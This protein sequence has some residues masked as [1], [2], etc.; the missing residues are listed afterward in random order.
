MRL[1]KK[2]LPEQRHLWRETS[3]LADL[4][5][6][7]NQW[8]DALK[9]ERVGSYYDIK[10]CSGHGQGGHFHV[11]PMSDEQKLCN[12]ATVKESDDQEQ[13]CLQGDREPANA[14]T[15]D[16]ATEVLQG[17][18]CLFKKK[19]RPYRATAHRRQRRDSVTVKMNRQRWSDP[20]QEKSRAEKEGQR[21]Q[22]RGSP[23]GL[24]PPRRES[25]S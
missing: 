2:G 4:N 14:I 5:E 19:G 22:D 8:G 15:M 13:P 16:I 11:S 12:V 23:R 7:V 6:D 1:S 17:T 18:K 25:Q 21:P 20:R 10:A 9:K 24:H 3:L